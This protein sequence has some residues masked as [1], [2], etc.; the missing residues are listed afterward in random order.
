MSPGD[1][2]RIEV[3]DDGAG[4]DAAVAR[5]FEPFFTTRPPGSGTGLGMA[6]VYGFV[7]GRAAPSTCAAPEEGTTVTLWLPATEGAGR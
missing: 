6:V 4:M 3:E 1:C 2:V 7:A 5:V